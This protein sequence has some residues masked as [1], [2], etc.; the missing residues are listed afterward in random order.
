M[1]ISSPG[2]QRRCTAAGRRCRASFAS[3]VAVSLAA[4]VGG[5]PGAAEAG[6]RLGG[7]AHLHQ[8]RPKRRLLPRDGAAGGSVRQQR[9]E[10]APRQLEGGL[11]VHDTVFLW[12]LRCWSCFACKALNKNMHVPDIGH[13]STP[14][15]TV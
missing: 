3:A 5:A 7:A 4:G 11:C 12:L 2:L 9:Q 15:L 1:F 10:Q 14:V 13:I 8:R 6:W